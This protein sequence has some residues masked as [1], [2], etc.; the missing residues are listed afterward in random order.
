[1]VIRNDFQEREQGRTWLPNHTINRMQRENRPECG[2]KTIQE[3]VL[4]LNNVPSERTGQNTDAKKSYNQ[5]D[6]EREQGRT[7]SQKLYNQP[8]DGGKTVAQQIP[9][10]GRSL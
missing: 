8:D 7:W 2:E 6:E 5:P 4:S 9:R 10:M 1:M 3:K